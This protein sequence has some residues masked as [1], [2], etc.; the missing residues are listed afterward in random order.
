MQLATDARGL[1]AAFAAIALASSLIGIGAAVAT[2]ML[3]RSSPEPA[4]D[5]ALA[6]RDPLTFLESTGVLAVAY[7]A[8]GAKRWVPATILQLACSGVL[9]V[10]DRRSA[11]M[12][13]AETDEDDDIQLEL[14]ALPS[15]F[16]PE[17]GRP[18][19]LVVRGIFGEHPAPGARVAVV[20]AGAIADRLGDAT[21]A[22]FARADERYVDHRSTARLPAVAA[23]ASAIGIIFALLALA[24]SRYATSPLPGIALLLGIAGSVIGRRQLKRGRL[25]SSGRMLRE[26][27]AHVA[28]QIH[29]SPARS[30]AD[31]ERL[32]PWAVLFD[33]WE[34]VDR[35][36]AVAQLTGDAPTWYRSDSSFRWKRFAS[37][38]EAIVARTSSVDVVMRLQW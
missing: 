37:C 1:F 28:T 8:T 17:D 9:A 26:R 16:G 32:L 35:L 10:I 6:A 19:A 33:Q 27:A 5:T 11:V 15:G 38:V 21:R 12:Q 18:G 4:T 29:A 34:A 25:N 3:L 22:G 24:L 30:V 2:A 14:V 23:T 36:G 7:V 31:G 20:R 13:S